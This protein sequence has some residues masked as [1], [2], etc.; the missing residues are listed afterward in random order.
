MRP[1]SR[2]L[3]ALAVAIAWLILGPMAMLYGSCA[4]MCDGCDMTCPA[5]PG[6]EHAPRVDPVVARGE[7]TPPTGKRVLTVSLAPPAPPPKPLRSA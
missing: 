4:I 5:A 7:T 6:V 1:R 3:L 2:S